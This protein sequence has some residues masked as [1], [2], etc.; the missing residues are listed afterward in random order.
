MGYHK[1]IPQVTLWDTTTVYHKWVMIYGRLRHLVTFALIR[2]VQ[3][4]R[5][6]IQEEN[7]YVYVF[8]RISRM[9]TSIHVYVCMY[10]MYRCMNLYYSFC[11]VTRMNDWC[12]TCMNDS[13]VRYKSVIAYNCSVLH[14][15]AVC[16][17]VLQCVTYKW[18][19]AYNCSV[20]HCVAVCCSV[21]Q[22]VAVCH[23]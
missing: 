20:L 18:V 4:A 15:V 2:M 13:C 19:V 9:H 10:A 8:V 1:H 5:I 11:F 12:V 17:S 21:L 14:C 3:I 22:C 7:T 6:R 23:I 16:C